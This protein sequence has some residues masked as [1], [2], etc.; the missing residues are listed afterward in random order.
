MRKHRG[1][2]GKRR[3]R[4][5]VL[6]EFVLILPV[7]LLLVF[8]GLD[9]AITVNSMG[10]FRSGVE[11]G[12]ALMSQGYTVLPGDPCATTT[13]PPGTQWPQNMETTMHASGIPDPQATAESLCEVPDA[14]GSVAGVDLASLQIAVACQNYIGT[15]VPCGG[16]S[17]T[18]GQSLPDPTEPVSFIVC[19]RA[20][21][22]SVTGLLS[23]ILDPVWVS[24]IGGGPIAGAAPANLTS[25]ATTIPVGPTFD[26]YNSNPPGP[27]DP[28]GLECPLAFNVTY[29]TTNSDGSQ[30]MGSAPTEPGSPFAA[31]APVT[32]VGNVGTPQ[33]TYGSYTFYAWCTTDDATAPTACTGT[34]YLPGEMFSMP[35]ADVTLYAQWQ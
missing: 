14:I 27:G 10:S 3:E 9:A 31:G 33:L 19:G 11:Q 17:Y 6:V 7:F 26:S 32:V 20:H 15:V 13:P 4:G 24:A 1:K 25:T 22:Q 2:P 35:A 8:G 30:A 16:W 5:A 28:N 21:A 18:T 23:P 29:S 12:A 34:S